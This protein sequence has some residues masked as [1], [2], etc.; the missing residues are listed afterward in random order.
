M[1]FLFSPPVIFTLI[2]EG[3]VVSITRFLSPLVVL[4]SLRGF[5]ASSVISVTYPAF[6]PVVALVKAFSKSYL[7]TPSG[8]DF[9]GVSPFTIL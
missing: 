9:A 2:A 8:V 6:E 5:P 1:Y 3:A 4:T 7:R